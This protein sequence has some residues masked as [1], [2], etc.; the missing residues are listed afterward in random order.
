M[1]RNRFTDRHA[2]G[3]VLAERLVQYADR[4][5]VVVLALPRGGVPVGHEVARALH[6]P[7]DVFIVRKVGAPQ[8]PELAMGAIASG[9]VEVI[10]R[11]TLEALNIDEATFRTVA[12]QELIELQRREEAYRGGRPP[13]DVRGRIVILVDD[14]VAT[15]ASMQAAVL[16]LRRQEPARIIVAVPVGAPGTCETLR[17]IADD[18][19]CVRMPEPFYAIGL[20]YEDFSQTR[21]QEVRKMLESVSANTGAPVAS[22]PERST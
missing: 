12:A 7:L 14:G 8:Q 11:D 3:Q 2:A 13:R 4:A 21:D 9:G 15:G 22:D 18:V 5:D 16:A 10:N 20:W 6:A 1:R 17:E 19:V